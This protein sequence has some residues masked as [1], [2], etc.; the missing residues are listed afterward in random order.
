MIKICKLEN[1][2]SN[3]FDSKGTLVAY[4]EWFSY[5]VSEGRKYLYID[6]MLLQRG[7]ILRL[8]TY[9][10][11]QT[12]GQTDKRDLRNKIPSKILKA[13]QVF[14]MARKPRVSRK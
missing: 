5:S 6:A 12:D 8:V 14:C 10:D 7:K 3:R 2:F 4:T 9:T 13:T 1:C 11:K